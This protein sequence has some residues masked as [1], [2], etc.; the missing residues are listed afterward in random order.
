MRVGISPLSVSTVGRQ[1]CGSK[2]DERCVAIWPP[3]MAS[4]CER[5]SVLRILTLRSSALC[6]PPLS[7][8]VRGYSRVPMS[9]IL[10]L[11]GLVMNLA[12]EIREGRRE[13]LPRERAYSLLRE[14]TG[15]DFGYDASRWRSSV[16]THPRPA[17]G[18]FAALRRP[19]K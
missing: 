11:R 19:K 1:D 3:R 17:F 16:R 13:Y 8:V 7:W 9:R 5:Y 10:P 2:F 6:P 15:K 18:P 12:G 4:S 14:W